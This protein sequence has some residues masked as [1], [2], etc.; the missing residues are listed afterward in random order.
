MRV[1]NGKKLIF[2]ALVS[3]VLLLGLCSTVTASASN[4]DGKQVHDMANALL[5][6]N[7][8]PTSADKEH[9][10][11]IANDS[12]AS[13]Q[14][15]EV[16]RII[17]GLSHKASGGDRNKLQAIIDDSSTSEHVRTIANIIMNLNHKPSSADKERLRTMMN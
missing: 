10:A 3:A 11:A 12:S 5:H 17:M 9:L 2:V 16:A 8:H 15:R 14:V 4:H 1:M 13:A 7:H 6:M